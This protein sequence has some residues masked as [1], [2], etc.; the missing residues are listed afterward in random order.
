MPLPNGVNPDGHIAPTCPSAGWLGNRGELHD[1]ERL[2]VRDWKVKAWVTCQLSYKGWNRKPLMQ[3][4]RYTE[5]FFLD[6]ATALAAG[7]RPCGMCR[8]PSY[9]AFKRHWLSANECAHDMP[10][11]E[12]DK[13]LHAERINRRTDGE[14]L[15]R[16]ADLP[17][18]V[19]VRW[20]QEV[21]IWDG[22]SLRRWEPTGYSAPVTV[23]KHVSEVVVITP[24]SVGRAIAAGYIV[25]MHESVTG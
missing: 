22:T 4:G 9:S 7:H 15:R 8:N 23:D 13:L 19:M 18:A 16:L 6:E 5:L 20:N 12:M 11:G 24:P 10:I 17:P 2:L 21:H 25:Q 1:S 3:P 14:W